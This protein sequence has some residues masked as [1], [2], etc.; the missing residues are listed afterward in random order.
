M[1]NSEVFVLM[2]LTS[3]WELASMTNTYHLRCLFSE[4]LSAYQKLRL[5]EAKDML[6]WCSTFWWSN[7]LKFDALAKSTTFDDYYEI[8][9]DCSHFSRHWLRVTHH[10][11]PRSSRCFCSMTYCLEIGIYL[12]R[13]AGLARPSCCRGWNAFYCTKMRSPR[14]QIFKLDEI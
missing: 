13:I 11:L 12:P 9:V 2:A 10:T 8:Y 14:F 6:W 5:L 7:L 3:H 1:F 4:V